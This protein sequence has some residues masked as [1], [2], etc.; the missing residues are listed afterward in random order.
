MKKGL[1]I[2]DFDGTLYNTANANYCA[3]KEA[4]QLYDYEMDKDTYISQYFGS[5]YLDFLSQIIGDKNLIE[6]VHERKVMLYTK[7]YDS[8]E[9]NKLLFD[10]LM[11]I[12][13]DYY[14]A[15]LTNASRKSCIEILRYFKRQNVFDYIVTG[16]DIKVKRSKCEGVCEIINHFDIPVERV[17]V[18]EDDIRNIYENE[19]QSFVL[20]NFGKSNRECI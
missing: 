1:V 11:H 13:K 6:K 14:I 10:I 7:Y 19:V 12:R 3:Y 20:K 15:L 17:L 5:P 18:I 9:E 8:I 16:D 4:L 2:V